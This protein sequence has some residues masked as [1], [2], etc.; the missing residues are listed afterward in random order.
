[1]RREDGQV[2][3]RIVIW[4]ALPALVFVIMSEA[5]L[6]ASLLLVPVAALGVHLVLLPLMLGLAR[7]MGRD[8]PTRGAMATSGAVGNTGFFGLPLI[9]AA[10]GGFSL[11]AAVMYDSIGNGIITWV[12]T[13]AVSAA[14]GEG[15]VEARL[16]WRTALQG[17]LLPPIWALVAGLI[18]NLAG[19]HDLPDVIEVPLRS[20]GGAVLPLVMVYAGLMLEVRGLPR[21]WREVGVVSVVKLGLAGLVG[22]AIGIAL[23]LSGPVLHTVAIMAAM[24]TAMMSLVFGAQFRLPTQLI[25]GCV[26]VTTLLA[27]VTL[28]LVRALV[29]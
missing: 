12:S 14:H 23:G 18:V 13:P 17:L 28:P 29:T 5:S 6:Q 25:A 15:S 3:V 19:V 8:R 1:M 4:L 26:V 2:L 27:T 9:A 7:L 22:L 21:V 24:P 16:G 11:P 10:G 20:L